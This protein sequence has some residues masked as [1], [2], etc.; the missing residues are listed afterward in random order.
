M[1]VVLLRLRSNSE[2]DN[3]RDDK[4]HGGLRVKETDR[5]YVPNLSD[6][7]IWNERILVHKVLL[8]IVAWCWRYAVAGLLSKADREYVTRAGK[9]S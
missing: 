5:Y 6:S 9:V 3:Q 1:T 8:W 4:A 7:L 2:Q